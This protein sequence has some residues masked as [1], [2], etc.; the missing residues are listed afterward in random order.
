M[1]TQKEIRKEEVKEG[2]MGG[3]IDGWTKASKL[4]AF[5]LGLMGTA[6]GKHP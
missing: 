4:R 6:Y 2:R 1:K 5:P 3:W